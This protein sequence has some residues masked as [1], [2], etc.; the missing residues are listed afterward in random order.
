MPMCFYSLLAVLAHLVCAN[1]SI[2]VYA[3]GECACDTSN[4]TSADCSQSPCRGCGLETKFIPLKDQICPET[5]KVTS[6]KLKD[7]KCRAAEIQMY[8]G[9]EDIPHRNIRD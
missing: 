5:S 7:F 4:N 9:G 2:D 1:F 3:P 6:H 8:Q